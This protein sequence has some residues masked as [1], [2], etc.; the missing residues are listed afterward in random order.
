ML[1]INLIRQ[2]PELVRKSLEKRQDSGKLSVLEELIEAD[3]RYRVLLQ[4]LEQLRQKRNI[5]SREINNLKANGSDVSQ[6]ILEARQLPE[7]IKQNEQ[8]ISELKEKIHSNLMRL[9]N[10]LDSSVPFG[11]DESNNVE[12]RRFGKQFKPAFPLKHHGELARELGIADFDSAVKIS[13]E[14]FFALKAE[15]ALLERA[16]MQH[17][18]NFLVKKGF[19]LVSPPLMMRRKP[20]EG[21][22]DLEDFEKVMYKIEGEDLYLIATSEHPM[23]AMNFGKIFLD[24]ELPVKWCGIS[25]NFRK[26]SGKHGLDERGLFR[27]HQFNKIEQII[28]C[29]PEESAK[30]HEEIT[31]NMEE[32]T[33]ALGIPCRIVNVCTGDLGSVAAKKYD[34][35]GWSAREQKFIELGSSSN[36]TAY[37]SAALGIKIRRGEEKVFAH[38]L[39]ATALATPRTLRLILE[40]FQQKDCT[41]S[42]PKALL[43]YMNGIKI[44]GAK[45]AIKPTPKPKKYAKPKHAKKQLSK[46]KKKTK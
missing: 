9:P 33:K 15:L 41:V 28:V 4:E 37:Q 16:L 19:I 36:C 30:F 12:L 1:D 40:N 17:A 6:K 7:K 35:E 22:V 25:T 27:L 2:N 24:K 43:P 21:C 14:G 26:E 44:L 18:I 11:K 39:N 23:I 8:A 3:K 42:I 13:G 5:L 10:I 31:R 45:K 20:Y 32:I 46:K 38:T 29:R 34:L